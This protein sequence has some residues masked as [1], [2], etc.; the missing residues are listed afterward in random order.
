VLKWQA[1]YDLNYGY[2]DNILKEGAKH[3]L[4][5]GVLLL[6]WGDMCY[7]MGLSPGCPVSTRAQQYGWKEIL[8]WKEQKSETDEKIV[9]KEKITS[10]GDKVNARYNVIL[11]KPNKNIFI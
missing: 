1:I 11:L 8:R 6:V 3:L 2:L 5:G 9:L 7:R 4:P 10:W